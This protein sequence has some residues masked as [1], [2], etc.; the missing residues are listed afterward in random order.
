MVSE[1]TQNVETVSEREQQE[2][3]GAARPSRSLWK[4]AGH[5]FIRNRIA[6]ASAVFLLAMY[7]TPIFAPLIAPSDPNAVDIMSVHGRP[8]REHPLGTDE[9]GRDVLSRVIIGS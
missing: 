6:V 3:T 9:S 1:S 8:S 7:T 4:V 2:L 5:R